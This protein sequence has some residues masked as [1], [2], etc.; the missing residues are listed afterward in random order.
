MTHNFNVTGAE[1]LLAIAACA[2][3]T[4]ENVTFGFDPL[5]HAGGF[6]EPYVPAPALSPGANL[7]VS[8]QRTFSSVGA[9]EYHCT[10]HQR[11]FG[12]AAN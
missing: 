8:V 12:S 3:K 6:H 10:I 11:M 5:G 1:A 9:R 4:G 7:H 2:G